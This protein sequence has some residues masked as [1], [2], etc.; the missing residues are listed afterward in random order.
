MNTKNNNT[1]LKAGVGKV[2]ITCRDDETSDALLSEKTKK[3]IPKEYLGKKIEIDDPLFVR[4]LVLEDGCEKVVLITMDITA[5]GGRSISQ[6][7]LNDSA[8]DFMPN[9]RKRVE[10]E[11]GIPG[12]NVSVSASHTHP[13][14]RL[15]CD[16]DA[17]IERT[18][19]AIKQALQNMVPVTFGTGS[20]YENTLTFNRTMLMKDGTD[21][22]WRPG[23]P[24]EEVE[25]LRPI[26]PEIGILRIDRLDGSPLAV[27]Y[28]FASHLL[29]GCREGKITADFPGVTSSLLE[30][31]LGADVMAFFTQG[32]GGDIMEVFYDDA[33]IPNRKY[34]F[35]S[36]LAQSTLRGYRKI[37]TGPAKLKVVT[38]NIEFPLRTDIPDLVADLKKEQSEI[39]ASLTY[40]TLDFKKFLPLYLKHSLYPDYPSHPPYRYMKAE[41]CGDDNFRIRDELNRAGVKKYLAG[42]RKMELLCISALKVATLEKHQEVIDE[43]GTA[44]VPA[45]IKGIRIGECV[46]IISPMEVLAEIGLNVKKKSPFKYTHIVSI[47]NGYLHYSPPASYYSRGGYE[48]TECLLAPEWEKIFEDTV[49][50]IFKEL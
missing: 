6:Y 33:E 38:K 15:L 45:E 5:I 49:D 25:G 18:L 47:S 31:N 34:D 46:L 9:L 42:I 35:G 12:D 19:K 27:M 2:D 50:E 32:A 40:T 16:D 11:L 26:D 36:K 13:P 23:P 37:E 29:V 41:E 7:I 48:V 3:H 28:N 22:T 43:I 21:Y 14:G 8:D 30:E 10:Q 4:A 44:T 17:Q 39:V 1:G 20:G 24:D